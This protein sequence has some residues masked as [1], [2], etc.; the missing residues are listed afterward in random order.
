ME[1]TL[2]QICVNHKDAVKWS[3]HP[4]MIPLAVRAE[5]RFYSGYAYLLAMNADGEVI[6][7]KIAAN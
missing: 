5:V 2:K 7:E 4:E 1:K 6:Y 3:Q